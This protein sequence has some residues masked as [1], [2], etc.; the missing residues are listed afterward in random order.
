V[1]GAESLSSATTPA[2]THDRGLPGALGVTGAWVAR[3]LYGWAQRGVGVGQVGRVT[4]GGLSA[5]VSNH[6]SG[7]RCS[8]LTGLTRQA[9]PDRP[10][11]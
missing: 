10:L 6:E 4:H 3:Q 11:T 2:C 8:F 9:S 1:P 5:W 7:P